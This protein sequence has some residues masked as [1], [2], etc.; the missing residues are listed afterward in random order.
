[1]RDSDV[2]LHLSLL[3]RQLAHARTHSLIPRLSVP[4]QKEARRGRIDALAAFVFVFYT[5]CEFPFGLAV[6]GFV[7]GGGSDDIFASA[8]RRTA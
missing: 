2:L 5:F 7:S 3:A 4:Y 1:M 6:P 8:G